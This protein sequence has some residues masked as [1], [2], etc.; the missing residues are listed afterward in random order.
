[1]SKAAGIQLLLQIRNSPGA[2]PNVRELLT[3]TRCNDPLSIDELGDLAIDHIIGEGKCPGMSLSKGADGEGW[4][5]TRPTVNLRNT[6]PT[7]RVPKF[8]IPHGREHSIQWLARELD[9][10]RLSLAGR[11][12]GGRHQ[13]VEAK[14]KSPLP[15]L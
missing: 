4:V 1:M 11:L 13:E 6:C 15:K 14:E 7:L 12:L 10:D 2:T 8:H 5:V 3:T 9:V